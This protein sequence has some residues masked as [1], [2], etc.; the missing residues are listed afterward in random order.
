MKILLAKKILI[1]E[2]ELK[3]GAKGSTYLMARSGNKGRSF[4]RGITA[5]EGLI[6]RKVAMEGAK[7]SSF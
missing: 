5:A 6:P 4:S 1:L 3:C 7:R 2:L